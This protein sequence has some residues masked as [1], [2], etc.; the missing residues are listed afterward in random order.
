MLHIREDCLEE[1]RPEVGLGNTWQVKKQWLDHQ[2]SACQRTHH[3]PETPL[4]TALGGA[5]EARPGWVGSL[6]QPL[7]GS[8]SG[9][10][11]SVAKLGTN[12][13]ASSLGPSNSWVLPLPPFSE[14]G[15]AAQEPWISGPLGWFTAK[16]GSAWREAAGSPENKPLLDRKTSSIVLELQ[17]PFDISQPNSLILWRGKLRHR[18]GKLSKAT[19]A[20]KSVSPEA[21]ESK[22]KEET[23]QVSQEPWGE[24]R[25]KF[26]KKLDKRRTK[27]L[28]LRPWTRATSEICSFLI[29]SMA[30][31]LTCPTGLPGELEGTL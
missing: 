23:R 2:K 4:R 1:V 15:P 7:S 19:Q 28:Y 27:G 14:L 25:G 3:C 20:E 30:I 26:Q 16:T 17:V 6:T 13:P 10:T 9:R 8:I 31:I 18:K 5:P 22:S 24:Q 29:C 21:G 12:A 11:T